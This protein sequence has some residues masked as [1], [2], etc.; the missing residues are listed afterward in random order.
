MGILLAVFIVPQAA[1]AALRV[2]GEV[3]EVAPL[4]P[5]PEGEFPNYERSINSESQPP[6]PG[7]DNFNEPERETA[8]TAPVGNTAAG[9]PSVPGR[10]APWWPA[11]ILLLAIA[12]VVGVVYFRKPHD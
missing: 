3:P 6:L 1:G 4:Q 10:A 11:A 8:S 12:A 7:S 2:E 5:A 9:S